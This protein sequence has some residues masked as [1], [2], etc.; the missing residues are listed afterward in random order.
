VT[1]DPRIGH[2]PIVRTTMLLLGLLLG[3]GGQ[4]TGGQDAGSSSTG[5]GQTQD[6]GTQPGQP[7][8]GTG[9]GMVGACPTS[10]PSSGTPCAS[11]SEQDCGYLNGVQPCTLFACD[12][13]G[14]W[15]QLPH[16]P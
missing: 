3:C 9:P 12:S 5:P 13:S 7:E 8:T 16:C 15:Q 2:D 4:V 6:S 14:H 11:P 1:A 10:A